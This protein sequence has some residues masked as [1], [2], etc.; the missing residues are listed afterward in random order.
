MVRKRKFTVPSNKVLDASC[1]LT[2]ADAKL[3]SSSD[4][5]ENLTSHVK[6]SKTDQRGEGIALYTRH[7]DHPVCA[8]KKNLASRG[9]LNSSA[10]AIP[11]FQL[12][13]SSPISNEG[14]V[15][16]V[17]HLLRLIG[18]D[19]SQYSRHSFRIGGATSA[20]LAGLCDYKST[21]WQLGQ[22][23]LPALHTFATK[24]AQ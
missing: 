13:G 11:F 16:F 15:T 8:R 20:S 10:T 3:H 12:A 23:L 21:Y 9:R 22:W 17:S 4:D 6:Q 18:I 19:P 7:S 1:H 24:F 5:M 14:P 2:A